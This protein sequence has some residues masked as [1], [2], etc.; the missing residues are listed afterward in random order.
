MRLL[1]RL[2]RICET[3]EMWDPLD[4]DSLKKEADFLIK[5][6]LSEKGVP[7]AKGESIFTFHLSG[8]KFGVKVDY[9]KELF[10]TKDLSIQKP[11][12]RDGVVVANLKGETVDVIV[13]EEVIGENYRTEGRFVVAFSFSQRVFGMFVDPPFGVERRVLEDM[14]PVKGI[15]AS[16]VEGECGGED[17]MVVLRV[18]GQWELVGF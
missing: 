16:L 13:P 2:S 14:L 1:E 17:P 9:V 6:M 7:R 12:D 8:E 4:A 11:L 3:F 18:E 5:A 10:R 15:D